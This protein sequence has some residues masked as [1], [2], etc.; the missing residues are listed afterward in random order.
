MDIRRTPR[1]NGYDR[2]LAG[3]VEFCEFYQQTSNIKIKLVTNQ[4]LIPSM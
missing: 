1:K 3:E 4:L 2:H